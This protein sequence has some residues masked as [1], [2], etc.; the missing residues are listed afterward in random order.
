MVLADLGSRL[1]TALRGMNSSTV[2][3]K[4]VVD[5]MM[6]EISNALM[7]ADVS[8]K[9]VVD[10]RKSLQARLNV[11]EMPQGA[12][13]RKIIQQTVFEELVRLVDPGTAPFQPTKGRANVI[14]FVGLQGAGKT[15]TVTKLAYWYRQRGWKAAM[16]CADTFRAGAFDQ[17]KQNATKA[18][19]PFFG[20]Y[21][22]ADPVK[23]AKDGVDRFTQEGYEI[24]IVDTSG[25]HKQEAALFDEMEQ[26]A[27]AVT[28]S[29]IIFVMDGSI[30]QAAFDQARAFKEKVDIGSVILTKLD[31]H[32]KG[33]GALS[34][35]AATKSPIVFIGT[36]EH[37]EDMEPFAARSFVSKLLGMGDVEGLVNTLK[38]AVDLEKQGPEMLQKL[39]SGT[40]T[41]RDMRE[42]FEMVLKMGP[43]NQ[44]M[45]MLPG[46]SNLLK[47]GSGRDA[48]KRI[49]NMMVIMDSMTDE[50]LDDIKAFQ[51]NQPARLTRIARGSGRSV[52][53]V[54]DLV[55][56]YKHF[57]KAMEKLKGMKLPTNGQMSQANL[58][59]VANMMPPQM[60]N[61]MGGAAGIQ[62]LMRSLGGMDMSQLSNMAA[63]MGM[64]PS[65]MRGGLGGGAG[66]GG[67][68]GRGRGRK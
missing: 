58:S 52:R 43:L 35:V 63:S 15:T 40:Y 1:T 6:K 54:S 59:R 68:R 17:L 12:N 39:T 46:M 41:F 61:Q 13:K 25:R 29:N 7:A 10:L 50:E 65:A 34:A 18:R 23:V 3:D 53:E 42:Q 20:S 51:K 26:V 60:R 27:A 2:I 64:D 24:I 66:R 4:Q 5:D 47:E 32:A 67:V 49:S 36:G 48:S 11:D 21:T 8:L 19:I 16:V 45:D 37:I 57:Q 38:G 31:G 14:M 22:E 9:L 33:G 30:G 44:V 56:Q 28:P 55:E 62:N